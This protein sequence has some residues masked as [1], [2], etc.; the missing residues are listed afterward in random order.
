MSRDAELN[1]RIV[2]AHQSEILFCFKSCPDDLAKI[3]PNGNILEIWLRGGKPACGCHR[4]I[5][6]GMNSRDTVS[7]FWQSIKIRGLQFEELP[8][9]FNFFNDRM[10]CFYL[11]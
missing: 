1:L 10:K 9:F 4:L 8:V 11:L 6:R 3:G 7:H 5:E 2:S